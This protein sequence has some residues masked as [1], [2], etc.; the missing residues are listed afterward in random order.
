MSPCFGKLSNS[1]PLKA[2][3]SPFLS[4]SLQE[5]FDGGVSRRVFLGADRSGVS[6]AGAAVPCS[7]SSCRAPERI[8]DRGCA[9]AQG[10]LCTA[11]QDRVLT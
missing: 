11:R 4:V 2:W 8:R 9:L 7:Q 3:L 6:L 5:R 10:I 1:W